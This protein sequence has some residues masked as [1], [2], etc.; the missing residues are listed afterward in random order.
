MQ[1]EEHKEKVEKAIAAI[2]EAANGYPVEMVISA[3]MAL[4]LGCL[5]RLKQD[6]EAEAVDA[7]QALLPIMDQIQAQIRVPH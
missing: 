7:A 2:G 4:V 5:L 6:D 1:S 3:C